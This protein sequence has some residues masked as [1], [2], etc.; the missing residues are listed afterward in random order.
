MTL[1]EFLATTTAQAGI[2]RQVTLIRELAAALD[3]DSSCLGAAVAG[4]LA[5]GTADRLSDVDLIVF[6]ESGS[7]V[8]LLSEIRSVAKT[9]D[10]LFQ[11]SGRHDEN[12]PYEKTILVD[13]FSYELHMI[14]P[15]TYFTLKAPFIELVN[16]ANT[17]EARFS[18]AAAPERNQQKAYAS[19]DDGL[20]WELF[21]CFKWSC[22]GQV[23][24][25]KRY[26]RRLEQALSDKV[27]SNQLVNL[28]PNGRAFV[29]G[30]ARF[31]HCTSPA[32]NT[33]PLCAGYR[34]R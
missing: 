24:D 7:A 33:L 3:A 28:T 31:A 18:N 29:S 27:M 9:T 2:E 21:N 19:G 26:I 25:A 13:M 10:V 5:K 4:S 32:P 8:R 34:Q 6:C 23:T 17:L 11:L 12:S 16:R 14:E 20:A 1:A 30:G 15:S 22:R